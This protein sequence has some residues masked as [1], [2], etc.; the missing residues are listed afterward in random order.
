MLSS[1][2]DR[3]AGTVRAIFCPEIIECSQAGRAADSALFLRSS[4]SASQLFKTEKM[5]GSRTIPEHFTRVTPHSVSHQHTRS[6]HTLGSVSDTQSLGSPPTKL[7]KSLPSAQNFSSY[8]SSD[9]TK[10]DR[11]RVQKHEHMEM[12]QW[13]SDS[14]KMDFSVLYK[15][16]VCLLQMNTFT[17]N[18]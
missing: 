4:G 9:K 16:Y 15:Q 13:V 12:S 14:P 1:V 2:G 5:W 3:A 17:Y 11:V 6:S 7:Q 8:L 10:F 18:Y